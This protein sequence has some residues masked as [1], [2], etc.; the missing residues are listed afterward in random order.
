MGNL[1][2]FYFIITSQVILIL[3]TTAYAGYMVELNCPSLA[4]FQ[5]QAGEPGYN[6]TDP[7]N[8]LTNVWLFLSLIFSGC[9][10]IP[11]WIY[12]IIFVPAL[13][14]VIV[15]VVPFIGG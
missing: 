3:L 5:A 8:A 13:I 1:Q 6:E 11:W 7:S 14:A 4:E 12:I 9:A 15:Y 10:G 2:T